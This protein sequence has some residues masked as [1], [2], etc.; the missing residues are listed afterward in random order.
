MT[1]DSGEDI[2]EMI[3]AIT[4]A[5]NHNDLCSVA[6]A[7]APGTT[8]DLVGVC[9]HLNERQ[10]AVTY[11]VFSALDPD[12]RV[13]LSDELPAAIAPRLLRGLPE[14]ER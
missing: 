9:E 5:L 12:D 4:R 3:D 10:R 7:I 6:A 14:H 13:W 11:R 2:N 1:I 8:S